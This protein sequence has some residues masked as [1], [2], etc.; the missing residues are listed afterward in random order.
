MRSAR[1]GFSAPAPHFRS[2]CCG[3]CGDGMRRAVPAEC[4]L[5]LLAG[6]PLCRPCGGLAVAALEVD[7]VGHRAGEWFM[8]AYRLP[9]GAA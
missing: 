7:G 6:R 4:A 2:A 9:Q 8:I 1:S 5:V 3:G